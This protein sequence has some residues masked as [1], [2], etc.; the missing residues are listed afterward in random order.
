MSLGELQMLKM[1]LDPAVRQLCFDTVSNSAQANLP[2]LVRA[3]KLR[4]DLCTN[5]DC[6][7]DKQL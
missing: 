7:F 2:T 5:H 4:H 6:Y 1:S 3:L